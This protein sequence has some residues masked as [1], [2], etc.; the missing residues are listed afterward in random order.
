MKIS[1]V[2]ASYNRKDIL[3]K[4]INTYHKQ[5]Y[6][7][8]EIIVVDNASIDGT[9]EMMAEKFPD[10]K[11]IYLPDNIDIKAINIAV[12][13]SSGDI[14]FRSDDDSYPSEE[15]L[16]E[17]VIER[18]NKFPQLGI[19]GTTNFDLQSQRVARWY[20][21]EVPF[22]NVPEYGYESKE[23]Q[24]TGGAI[25]KEVFEQV[26]GFWEF[27]YEEKELCTR[28]INAGWDVRYYPDLCVIHES[29]F[30]RK[31]KPIRWLKL[32]KQHIRYNAI[33]F[34]CC[35][36][37]FR[38][39]AVYFGEMLLGIFKRMPISA[40]LEGLLAIPAQAIHSR[41][42]EKN[43]LKKDVL[44]KI[45]IDGSIGRFYFNLYGQYIKGMISRRK[46]K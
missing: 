22:D 38:C 4:T 7:N 11:Y 16:F 32:A 20:H 13:H 28:A 27:G 33:Y 45:T 9:P 10:I 6:K 41:R 43:V 40:L 15:N 1:V 26:G 35:R 19:I 3:E 2:I 42:E 37:F 21:K 12:Y 25:R 14:I 17:R 29:A 8:F 34:P 23:F 39:L 18:F 31:E 44:K 46:A 36:A 24:G 30:N 5:T